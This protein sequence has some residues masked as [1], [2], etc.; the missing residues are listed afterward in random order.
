MLSQFILSFGS[1][2]RKKVGDTLE[3]QMTDADNNIVYETDID[4]DN[5]TANQT[6]TVNMENTVTIPK[7]VTCCIRLICSYTNTEYY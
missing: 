3:I 2:E 4:V 5:I 1:F 7:G 6:Y